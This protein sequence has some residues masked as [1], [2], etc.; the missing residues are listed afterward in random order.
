MHPLSLVVSMNFSGKQSMQSKPLIKEARTTHKKEWSQLAS[1][2]AISMR[3]FLSIVAK[4]PKLTYMT[5]LGA[6]LS[7]HD[8]QF[9]S[10]CVKLVGRDGAI[11]WRG[12]MEKNGTW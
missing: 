12:P 6:C 3:S 1:P 11:L 7:S 10:S 2:H 8:R 4:L 9:V 5:E